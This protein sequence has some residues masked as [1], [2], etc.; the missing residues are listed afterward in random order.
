MAAELRAVKRLVTNGYGDG[1][2]LRQITSRRCDE[3]MIE[4]FWTEAE[5]EAA[6]FNIVLLSHH[7]G[8]HELTTQQFERLSQFRF[9]YFSCATWLLC[10]YRLSDKPRSLV[11]E[12]WEH[13]RSSRQDSL[14]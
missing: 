6:G 1:D 3:M 13:C 2:S 5:A 4:E 9:L 12:H 14:A 8:F 11:G 7:D 10:G